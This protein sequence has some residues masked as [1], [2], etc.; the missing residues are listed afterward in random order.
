[1]EDDRD[2]GGLPRERSPGPHRAAL[3]ATRVIALRAVAPPARLL[4][5]IQQSRVGADAG[6]RAADFGVRG[7]GHVRDEVARR[8]EEAHRGA[9][10]LV[11]ETA[12][13]VVVVARVVVAEAAV[14]VGGPAEAARLAERRGRVGRADAAPLVALALVGA[15][16]RVVVLVP[17][18]TS[19]VKSSSRVRC[20]FVCLFATGLE[21]RPL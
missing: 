10:D 9:A 13:G 16:A 17:L 3:L 11:A 8:R 1:M 19:R 5:S 7:G 18:W 12:R 21:G 14:L 20:V 15:A 6:A 2:V 4:A